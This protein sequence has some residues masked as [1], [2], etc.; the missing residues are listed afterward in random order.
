MPPSAAVVAMMQAIRKTAAELAPVTSADAP[1]R[2]P[3]L[4]TAA[5][6]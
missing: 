2:A 1:A 3:A 4:E 5:P 6:A